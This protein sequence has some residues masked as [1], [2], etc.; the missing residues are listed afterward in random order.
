MGKKGIAALLAVCLLLG[1][2]AASADSGK[3]NWTEQER[4]RLAVGNPT[5]MQGRFF[6]TMWGGTTSDLDVQDLLH[7]Y[8]LA[9]YEIEASQ[10]LYDKS[11]VQ[12]AAAI[13]DEKGN[14]TY[15]IVLYD[16]LVWSDG[17]PITAYDYAFS[18]LLCMDPVIGETG[19]KPADYSWIDGA[20]AY[21]KGTNKTLSGLRVVAE[22]I[23]QITVKAEALPY[24]FEL[25]R[26][27][28]Y[29]YPR[30]VIAPGTEVK[31]DGE[32]AYLSVPLTAE[33][34]RQTVLDEEKGYLSHPSVVS[35]PYTLISF[36]GKTAKMEIN[37]NFKGTEAG[38]VPRIGEIE[39]TTADN[40][41]M[42]KKLKSGELDLLD[43]V[44]M[45][46][47]IREGM[48]SVLATQGSL[49]M[50]NEPRVGLTLIRFTESSKKVQETAV[51]K[52]IGLCFNRNAFVEQYVGP[53]G[54]RADG[55][56]GLGQWAYRLAA[57]LTPHP[58]TAEENE[59]GSESGGADGIE[60]VMAEE[61]TD[62]EWQGITLEGLTLYEYNV[63]EAVRLLEEAGWNLNEEGKP[64]DPKKDGVRYKKTGEELTGLNLMMAIP[65]SDDT[66]LAL[67]TWLTT[68]LKAAGINLQ[69]IPMDMDLLA[70]QFTGQVKT[71]YDMLYAGENFS[72][73]LNPEDFAPRTD[74]DSELH[75]ALEEVRA[76]AWETVKTDPNNLPEYMRKW[77]RMQEQISETLPVLPVYMDVYFDFYSR[78]LHNYNIT[79]AVSWGEAIV[80]SFISDIEELNEEE[81]QKVKEQKE[82]MAEWANEPEATPAPEE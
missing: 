1:I 48:K 81:Q 69:V 78:K 30:Q 17:T 16:D 18:I 75:D 31:D 19:G 33:T 42:V 51:R 25:S 41:N 54:L 26:L 4:A 10:F 28:I 5:E 15:L 53:F 68:P 59:A 23:L 12:G 74:E 80:S 82:E 55:Y 2:A 63:D 24:F 39:Y 60:F 62:P 66:W 8:S 64:F 57:G 27:M 40:A 73:I 56:Y 13:D 32:G 58:G 3:I 38:M 29:P 20:E 36:D 79:D 6:T 34:I 7:A 46:R 37:P 44:T 52:A 70:E 77:V 9:R 45:A 21:L 22:Q 76:L 35:G 72:L 71:R 61:D 49:A 11:V 50:Q 43:K 67:N 65:P 14:R 47:T